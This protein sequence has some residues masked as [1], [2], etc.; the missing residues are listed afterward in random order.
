VRSR[1]SYVNIAWDFGEGKKGEK[2]QESA[3]FMRLVS[4]DRL[5]QVRQIHPG[6]IY[7][8]YINEQDEWEKE[9]GAT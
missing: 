5:C 4:I 6:Y 3:L 2:I 1:K 7:D 8:T 9:K